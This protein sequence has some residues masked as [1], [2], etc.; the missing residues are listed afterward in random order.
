MMISRTDAL[1]YV[2]IA[3]VAAIVVF[4][5]AVLLRPAASYSVH[6]SMQP[7]GISGTALYPYQ[8]VYFRVTV[9]NTGQAISDMPLSIYLNNSIFKSYKVSIPAHES[10]TIN[11][12]YVFQSNGT[13]EFDAV[14]DPGDLLTLTNRSAATGTLSY[15]VSAP[16]TPDLYAFVPNNGIVDTHSFTLFGKGAAL[17]VVLA[18]AYNVS[19]FVPYL[20]QTPSVMSMLLVDLVSSGA[21]NLVNGVSSTYLNGTS[22]YGLWIQGTLNATSIGT[23][24]AT[25]PFGAS[26][27]NIANATAYYSRV[28]NRTSICA[29]SANGWTKLLEYYNDSLP[30]T[31][32]TV[33]GSAYTPILANYTSAAL[34]V[35]GLGVY[36]G[37]FVYVNSSSEG[38]GIDYNVSANSIASI[39]F[40]QNAYGDF[41][42]SL[43]S[44]HAATPPANNT[45]RGLVYTNNATNTSMCSVYVPAVQNGYSNESVVMSTDLMSD[46]TA[47]VYSFVNSPYT[48]AAHFNAGSL[49]S[50]LGI[51]ETSARWQP[52]FR[53]SCSFGNVSIGCSVLSFNSTTSAARINISNGLGSRIRINT[54][55]CY[56]T[57]ARQNE[58]VNATLAPGTSVTE[59]VTCS[60]SYVTLASAETSYILAMNY[61]V[62]GLHAGASGVLNA[63]NVYLG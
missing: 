30:G 28:D 1:V 44:H 47:S 17:A 49:I 29:F 51:N 39:N 43:E 6:V 46:Y 59:N 60:N 3:V 57:G 22:A 34:A 55:A 9:D 50:K 19:A 61:T 63:T 23:L 48:V 41:A 58:T 16:Q 12:T 42:T 4:A 8:P 10:A 7:V 38:V 52:A 56:L 31:C 35:S 32:I 45:C 14:A 36:G 62:N 15:T 13:Y 25:Y 37:N 27:T 5:A 21:V 53:N 33:A 26:A 18:R 24:L 20:G 40:F 54:L 2:G 11:G